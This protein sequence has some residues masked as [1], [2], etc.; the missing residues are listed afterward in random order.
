MK[1]THDEDFTESSFLHYKEVFPI[2]ENDGTCPICRGNLYDNNAYNRY[3]CGTCSYTLDYN[4]NAT[5][6]SGGVQVRIIA[7]QELPLVYGWDYPV[8]EIDYLI[9]QIKDGSRANNC[10]VLLFNERLYEIA[11]TE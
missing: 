4:G 8:E 2:M 5:Y 7:V 10:I 1:Y 3:E 11:A 6:Y 9:E